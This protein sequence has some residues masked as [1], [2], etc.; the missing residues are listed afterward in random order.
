MSLVGV[1]VVG[2]VYKEGVVGH[3]KR[4]VL[5]VAVVGGGAF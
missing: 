1:V 2:I 3:V 5:C 4:W